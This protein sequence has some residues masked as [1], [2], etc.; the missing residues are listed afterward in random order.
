M[1]KDISFGL[2]VPHTLVTG[3]IMSALALVSIDGL[4]VVITQAYGK[5]IFGLG[6]AH[7]LIPMQSALEVYGMTIYFCKG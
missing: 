6:K 5:M 4:K 7:T 2:T 1:V 3:G